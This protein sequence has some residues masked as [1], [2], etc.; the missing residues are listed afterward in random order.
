VPV[1]CV[2]LPASP[3]EVR[4]ALN[5]QTLFLVV[6]PAKAGIQ[7]F[8]QQNRIASLSLKGEGRGEGRTV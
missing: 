2:A 1:A 7:H 3:A 6:I 8:D 4:E 5:K